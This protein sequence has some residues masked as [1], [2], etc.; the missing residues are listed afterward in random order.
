MV[1][2]GRSSQQRWANTIDNHRG[3]IEGVLKQ[4]P[5]RRPQIDE[6]VA[7]NYPNAVRFAARDTHRPHQHSLK[8]IPTPSNKPST[9]IFPPAKTK[10]PLILD[11]ING[12]RIWLRGQD[13]C[14]APR[15]F[16]LAPYENG[17][18]A[19]PAAGL[20]RCGTKCITCGTDP[21]RFASLGLRSR[22]CGA[23]PNPPAL[24]L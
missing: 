20:K 4:M 16:T 6:Y 21:H 8:K 9:S 10:K 5:S 15:N 2:Y 12:F 11:G 18:A 17:G 23:V 7:H 3:E 14:P 22:G 1:P 13:K 24:T 19:S